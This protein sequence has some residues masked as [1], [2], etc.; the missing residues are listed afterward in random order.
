[1][2]DSVNDENN[3][4]KQ[5]HEN[6]ADEESNDANDAGKSRSTLLVSFQITAK[7]SCKLDYVLE[8]SC[9]WM[10]WTFRPCVLSCRQGS[11]NRQFKA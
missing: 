11:R 7:M 8:N 3:H 9:Q 5:K 6:G 10:F 2:L 4:K 1:M